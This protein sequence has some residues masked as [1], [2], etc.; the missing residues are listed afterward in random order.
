MEKLGR[1]A[2]REY[3]VT[4]FSAVMPRACGASSTPRP[5]GPSTAASGIL[6]RPIPSTPGFD[7]GREFRARRSFGEGGKSGDDGE[8]MARC[9]PLM[10]R[11]RASAVSGRCS[12][13]P[14]EPRRRAGCPRN[15]PVSPHCPLLSSGATRKKQTESRRQIGYKS[16]RGRFSYDSRF[17]LRPRRLERAARDRRGAAGCALCLCRR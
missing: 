13:S 2:P 11:R 10:V 17:R 8:S 9:Q 16:S 15:N 3:I 1:H 12:A 4:P 6:D 5:L 14:G 7:E